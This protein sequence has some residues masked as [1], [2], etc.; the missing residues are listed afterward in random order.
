MDRQIEAAFLYLEVCTLL[1]GGSATRRGV[2]TETRA[3]LVVFKHYFMCVR[4]GSDQTSLHSY[5]VT[6][7][8]G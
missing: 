8:S 1:D 7:P 6:F 4:C 2:P 5:E 3:R